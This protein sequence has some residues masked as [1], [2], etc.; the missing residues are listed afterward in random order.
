MELRK[1]CNHPF[2]VDGVEESE[3]E[4]YEEEVRRRLHT[5]LLRLGKDLLRVQERHSPGPAFV[6]RLVR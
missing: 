4:K 5:P 6:S 2:L 1:C 3:L